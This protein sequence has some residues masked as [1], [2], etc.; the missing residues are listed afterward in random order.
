MFPSYC[1]VVN[2]AFFCNIL[3]WTMVRETKSSFLEELAKAPSDAVFASRGRQTVQRLWAICFL[4]LQSTV[5]PVCPGT[6]FVFDTI[7][8]VAPLN[9]WF[10]LNGNCPVLG[11]TMC[12]MFLVGIHAMPDSLF[13]VF[14]GFCFILELFEGRSDLNTLIYLLSIW[15]A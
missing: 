1:Q 9:S 15:K 7:T 14:S 8:Q 3:D 12:N 13:L 10:C 4:L 5:L 6:S 11:F 2:P